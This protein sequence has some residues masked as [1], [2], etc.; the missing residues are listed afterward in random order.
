MSCRG[1]SVTELALKPPRQE[2]YARHDDQGK[3]YASVQDIQ[4]K[5]YA[6]LHQVDEMKW[7]ADVVHAVNESYQRSD[8]LEI[9]KSHMGDFHHADMAHFQ[10]QL[11]IALRFTEIER[12]E[13]AIPLAY[14][15]TYE[16]IFEP[17]SDEQKWSSFS[18]WLQN[19]DPLYWITGKAGSGKSTLMKFIC[20]HGLTRKLLESGDPTSELY[21]LSFYFWNSGTAIQ[22]S[23]EGLIRTFLYQITHDMPDLAPL[24]FPRRFELYAY[25]GR[26]V[27]WREP[28]DWNELASAFQTFVKEVTTKQKLAIFIDGLDEY[29]GQH[30]GLLDLVQSFLG[31]NIKMCVSSRPWVIFEDVFKARPS[32]RVEDLSQSDMQYFVDS[33]LSAN[34]GFAVLKNLNPSSAADLI[35]KVPKKSSGVFL[36]TFLVTQSLLEGLSNGERLTDLQRRLESLPTDLEELFWK[37]LKSLDEWHFE[38]AAQLFQIMRAF[39]RSPSM[40]RFALADEDDQEGYKMPR[41]L[42]ERGQLQARVE[43][44]RRRLNACTK[45]LLEPTASR[46]Q[47]GPDT[48]V[49]YLHRTVHDFIEHNNVFEELRRAVEPD[50]NPDFRL[51]QA[52]IMELKMSTAGDV[53]GQGLTKHAV[54]AMQHA[55][56]ADPTC[57]SYQGDLLDELDKAASELAAAVGQVSLSL[58]SAAGCRHWAQLDH[59]FYRCTSFL[60]VAVEAQLVPYIR[61]K[62]EEMAVTNTGRSFVDLIDELLHIA[63]VYWD[64]SPFSGQNELYHSTWNLELIR[65]ILDHGANPLAKFGDASR[66]QSETILA[67]VQRSTSR[68]DGLCQVLQQYCEKPKHKERSWK[69]KKFLS[70]HRNRS[71]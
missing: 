30:T 16:W 17:S 61:K 23:Q 29:D 5:M 46:D 2:I 22:M 4:D 62:L 36:W 10:K 53:D 21:L 67:R 40:L 54:I 31:P 35:D 70:F 64:V 32:L 33:K 34:P 56:R 66:Y 60:H 42:P 59:R 37:M 49:Q 71:Q 15:K 24:L 48:A 68:S 45:G 20:H 69:G 8:G 52:Y 26:L 18:N 44:F 57:C 25:L 47:V 55:V 1:F 58:L 9:R 43:L 14:Q 41:A 65:L 12:R 50:F 19:D 51:S 39:E 3:I 7:M 11:K 38:R 6:V 13:E 27:A 63:A 28:L